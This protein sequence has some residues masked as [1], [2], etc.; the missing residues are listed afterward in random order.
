MKQFDHKICIAAYTR[1]IVLHEDCCP[2]KRL[3]TIPPENG[4]EIISSMEAFEPLRTSIV[5]VNQAIS[6]HNVIQS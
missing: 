5:L 2:L 4:S 6:C 3:I 1:S